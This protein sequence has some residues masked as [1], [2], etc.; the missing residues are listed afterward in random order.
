MLAK[1]DATHTAVTSQ[2]ELLTYAKFPG[3]TCMTHLRALDPHCEWDFV[4]N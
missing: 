1:S 3:P 4:R 2:Q